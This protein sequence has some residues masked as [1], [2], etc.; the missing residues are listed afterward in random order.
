MMH[1]DKY[2]QALLDSQSFFEIHQEN[3]L[4]VEMD[5]FKNR[6]RSLVD[7]IEL[8]ASHGEKPYLIYQDKVISFTQHLSL[9]KKAAHILQ[10]EYSVKPGDRVAI[11]AANCPEWIVFFWA[12]VSLG[13]IACGLNGWWKGSEALKAIDA[14]QPSIIVADQ[15]RSERISVQLEYPILIFEDIDFMSY[16]HEVNSFVRIDEDECACLLYTSGT[17]GTPKGV[18]TS[19]RSMIANSTLQMLQ[20]AAVSQLSSSYGIDWSKNTPTSLLTSPL[21]HVSGLSAGAVTSLFAG[22]TTLVYDGRFLADRVIELMQKFS[23]TSWGGAV[24]TALKRVLD[25]AKSQRLKLESVLVVGG[26]GAPMPPEL[27]DRTSEVFPNSQYSFGYGYGLTESGA[28]TII[29]W[30]ESLR[31]EPS[32]PGSPM[33]T[34]KI[35]LR[36]ENGKLITQDSS[37]GEIYVQSP[38]VMLGYYDNPDASASTLTNDRWLRTG[39]WGY[40]KGSL[41]FISSRR[42]DLILRGAENVYPQEIELILDLHEHVD[43]SAVI[44][45]PNDDLGQEVMAIVSTQNSQLSDDELAIWVGNE[46]ADFKVPSKWKFTNSPLPRNASGKLMKHVLI[47]TSKNILV[48]EDE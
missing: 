36:D 12:T 42:T 46:L 47:D 2:I 44:G 5:V 10:S 41:Y 17:T 9:V 25:E 37:E 20:G 15:K 38:S 32:S 22:S 11:Y 35:E 34:I 48:E 6:P 28:I 7:F 8:S 39:D 19:H 23:I 26:G 31:T 13:G 1:S 16:E 4:G 33:P 18:M 43:E 14:A 27:I 21:F 24:P 30:G 40:K 29:N 45:I 3:V